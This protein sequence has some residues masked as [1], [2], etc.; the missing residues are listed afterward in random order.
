MRY[1]KS[2]YKIKRKI[3]DVPETKKENLII[4]K[5]KTIKMDL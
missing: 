4:K 2:R 3:L 1:I 5:D